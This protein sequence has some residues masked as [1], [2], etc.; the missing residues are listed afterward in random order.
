MDRRPTRQQRMALMLLEEDGAD[1]SLLAEYCE[2]QGGY[3]NEAAFIL[4]LIDRGWVT[5]NL[6]DKGREALN[7]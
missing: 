6:T 4:R 2:V 5:L 7:A 3:A 1:A